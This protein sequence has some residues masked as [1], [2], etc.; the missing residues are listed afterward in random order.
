MDTWMDG[1]TDGCILNAYY[2]TTSQ[3]R[4][5]LSVSGGLLS[6]EDSWWGGLYYIILY[7]NV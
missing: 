3:S 1:R 5:Y 6:P 4:L 2:S 7:K